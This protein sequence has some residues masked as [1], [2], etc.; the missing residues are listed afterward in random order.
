MRSLV[1]VVVNP[2]VELLLGD[3]DRRER[4]IDQELLSNALME[5]FELSGRCRR[6]RSRQLV[7]DPVLAAHAIEH[8]FGLVGAEA[9][10]KN[11][12]IV[13]QDLVEECRR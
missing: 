13:G 7:R 12:A 2:P 3:V 1:V 8:H 9:S 5:P 6:T 10:V 4:A 11:L